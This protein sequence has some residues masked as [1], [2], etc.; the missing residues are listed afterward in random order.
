MTHGQERT[1]RVKVT[2][3]AIVDITD[4]RAL[5]Q[6]AIADIETADF[7]VS[8]DDDLTVAEVR[9][10]EQETVRGDTVAAVQWFVDA[11]AV[12]QD[13]AG[14]EFVEA[15][16]ATEE[17]DDQGTPNSHWPNFADLFPV[18]TCE[19]VTC[20]RC[21]GFQMTPRTATALWSAG[22]VLAD[23]AYDDVIEHGDDPVSGAEVWAVFDEYPRIT[24]HQNAIWR[25]QAARSF[26]DL[27][28]DLVAGDWPQP[29]CPAEEMALHLILRTA[30]AAVA[31]GWSSLHHHY[32]DLPEHKQ[33]L[34]WTLLPDILCQDLDI[35]GLFTDHLDGIEDPQTEQN[36]DMGIG[37]YR[38]QAWFETF[39]NM[40]QRDARRP[41][42][43]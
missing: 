29:R 37:D 10:L 24:K 36:R 31:D 22:Q 25:R 12:I 6:A 40:K 14:I 7:W 21:D 16:E 28:A 8:P 17:I 39:L 2:I 43:R 41:F 9:Q 15:T 4:P 27:C 30:E 20:D 3:E 42:R 34:N 26:D 13:Q 19:L 33:D 38:P 23:Q 35:L 32:A 18:C 11:G 1:R 5:E